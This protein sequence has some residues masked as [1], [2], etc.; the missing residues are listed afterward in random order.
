MSPISRRL[1][2]AAA[3][4]A[5]SSLSFMPLAL[6]ATESIEVVDV[7]GRTVTVPKGAQRLILGEGRMVYSIAP[8]DRENP[9]QRVVGWKD[10]LIKYDPDAYRKYLAKYPGAADIT[11]FGSPYAGDFSVEQAIAKQAD[12][13]ILNLGKLFDAEESGVLEKLGKAGIPVIFVDFRQRPTQNTVPSMLLL[14][15]VLDRRDEAQ[16]FVDFY[17]QQM[18]AVTTRVD[19]IPIEE[20]PVVFIENAAGWFDEGS[21][22]NTFGGAN[23]GRLVDEAGG[24]NWGTKKFPGYSSDVSFEAVLADDPAVVIGTGANWSD[25]KPAT[26]AVLLGYEATNDMVAKRI[27]ALAKRKGWQTT[28]AVK[29]KRYHSIYHQ[30]YNSP[31][32]FIAL[33]AFAKWFHPELFE[34]VDV[35]A[36]WQALHDRFLPIEPSGV[37]WASL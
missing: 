9:F 19:G 33:Q 10:D 37:F 24:I 2:L 15:R 17:L 35:D 26:T 20:R 25:A 23:F 30:F 18:R 16:A 1:M 6:Q 4:F 32:H 7:A 31:Y 14:G 21:C 3:A 34:D 12:L 11:N 8:L 5:A 13:V 27:G 22:C 36:N 28:T 29:T